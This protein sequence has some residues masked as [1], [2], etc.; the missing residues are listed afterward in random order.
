MS[1]SFDVLV[2]LFNKKQHIINLVD[3]LLLNNFGYNKVLII[4]D[5]ST[6]GSY[7][8]V[9]DKYYN[10]AMINLYRMEHNSGPQN[11][12]MK[13]Y[14]LSKCEWLFFI[15]ADD[16]VDFDGAKKLTSYI[17][18]NVDLIYGNTQIN[19]ALLKYSNILIVRQIKNDLHFIKYPK[20]TMTG[21][22]VRREILK[23]MDVPTVN[24]GEDLI[25]F[26][27][28][29]IN[30]RV[31]YVSVN[32][33]IYKISANSRGAGST[34]LGDRL[35][36]LRVLLGDILKRNSLLLVICGILYFIPFS[37]KTLL[38]GFYKKLKYALIG[39]KKEAS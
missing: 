33:G 36:F 38:A 28:V 3:S 10:N 16:F 23:Q 27:R 9:C 7:E 18:D 17:D 4:D 15:D 29:I 32:V 6:D 13:A 39:I 25:F 12:R 34:S 1:N 8:L 24:W 35:C 30:A 31:L 20:P 21:L 19:G 5:C 37:I 14:D 11:V 22:L 2:P 26:H